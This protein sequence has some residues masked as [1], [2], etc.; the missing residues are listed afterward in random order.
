MTR[1]ISFTTGF[2][3]SLICGTLFV[4][5][6]E[7]RI[8]ALDEIRSAKVF[9]RAPNIE[10][11]DKSLTK[12]V[13]LYEATKSHLTES[14]QAWEDIDVTSYLSRRDSRTASFA[15]LAKRDADAVISDIAA[16]ALEHGKLVAGVDFDEEVGWTL[17]LESRDK[18]LLGDAEIGLRLHRT[19][20]MIDALP[21]S[22]ADTTKIIDA[23]YA[24]GVAV[25]DAPAM[26][27][28]Q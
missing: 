19:L 11:V 18:V 8:P 5:Y 25:S 24:R 22:N 14:V 15:T 2:T 21:S 7:P 1:F 13:D 10:A 26:V 27:A 12:V 17:Q 16:I 3:L 28:M 20:S 9:E 6:F 4:I 23:R